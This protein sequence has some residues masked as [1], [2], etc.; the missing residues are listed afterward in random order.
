MPH[1][2][3]WTDDEVWEKVCCFAKEAQATG[4]PIY[5][6]T[7]KVWHGIMVVQRDTIVWHE[8]RATSATHQ[9][10][11]EDVLKV[12][13]RLMWT[14]RAGRMGA[15]TVPKGVPSVTFAL[16]LAAMSEMLAEVGHGQ[17]ALTHA[18]KGGRAVQ[19]YAG[20]TTC[21]RCDAGFESW[22][23]RQNRLCPR[24]REAIA[25]QPSDEPQYDL[26]MLRHVPTED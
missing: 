10:T 8:S 24:C 2:R 22:D 13:T 15:R 16:L 6:L 18:S 5:T 23:R 17:I 11:R 21:L 3:T 1:Y 7:Q 19:G 25:A 14:G 12:W 20:P 9:T 4:H 26:L